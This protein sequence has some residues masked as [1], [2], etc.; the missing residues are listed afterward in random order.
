[1]KKNFQ[2]ILDILSLPPHAQG[3]KVRQLKSSGADKPTVQK[4][5]EALLSLKN[6]LAALTG[7]PIEQPS[8]D[9]KKK[10]KKK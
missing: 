5:V 8:S 9:N 10:N 2:Q 6:K 7:K 1:V 3:N 4:E